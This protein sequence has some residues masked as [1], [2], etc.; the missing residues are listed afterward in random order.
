MTNNISNIPTGTQVIVPITYKTQP[1]ITIQVGSSPTLDVNVL[2]DTGS[3]WLV[4]NASVF[5]DDSYYTVVDANPQTVTYGGGDLV[6]TG[7]ICSTMVSIAGLKPQAVKF[8]LKQ[9]GNYGG[10]GTLGINT[11]RPSSATMPNFP[12]E[13]DIPVHA[14]KIK[15]YQISLSNDHCNWVLNGYP[16]ISKAI[17]S[18]SSKLREFNAPADNNVAV[19]NATL[20]VGT[21][22]C[23]ANLLL[24]SG[25]PGAGII[26]FTNT[27]NNQN[28]SVTIQT[29][30]NKVLALTTV[31]AKDIAFNNV[32]CAV[33]STNGII[34][35]HLFL[36]YTMG[37]DLANNK[38]FLLQN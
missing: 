17:I 5:P 25:T 2:M 34:G 11:W 10:N 6:A 28:M 26:L 24:D 22:T 20:T 36:S 29:S 37:I 21:F 32:T 4:L 16:A 9:K 19:T 12:S 3:A 8:L 1:M 13:L 14:L 18:S 30:D 27:P 38:I 23:S 33:P 15:Q 31:L 7:P 35:N